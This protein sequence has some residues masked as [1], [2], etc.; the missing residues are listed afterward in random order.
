[1]SQFA[2]A[3]AL[4]L[5]FEELVNLAGR[6]GKNLGIEN[7][8][9]K[10]SSEYSAWA[11]FNGG[12]D[13]IEIQAVRGTT[14]SSRNGTI[15]L[16]IIPDQTSAQVSLANLSAEA[17]QLMVKEKGITQKIEAMPR[18]AAHSSTPAGG[19]WSSVIIPMDEMSSDNIKRTMDSMSELIN[20]YKNEG[21]AGL[22]RIIDESKHVEQIK[23]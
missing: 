15:H 1:M 22:N 5:T 12:A 2:H 7:H 16:F 8:L 23:W 20:I 4:T 21:R 6:T 19:V 10:G 9:Q 17:L 18:Q 13:M 3:G 11:Y 14:R